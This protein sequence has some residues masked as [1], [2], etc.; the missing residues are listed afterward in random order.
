M[1]SY[2]VE[3]S[4]GAGSPVLLLPGGAASSRGFFPGLVEA[5]AGHQVVSLDRPGTGLAAG[6]GVAS[7][8]T[9]SAAAA[10]VLTSLGAGP[11][12]VVGQSLG[13]AVAVQFAMDHPS[14]VAGLVLIDP[15][16]VDIPK[17]PA[18]LVRLFGLL[19]LP[20]RLP[21]V[22]GRLDRFVWSAMSRRAHVAP[23]ARSGLEVMI[24]SA[25]MATTKKAVETLGEDVA[26]LGPRLGRLEVP[27][28]VMTADRKPG[29]A[30]RQSHERLVAALGGRL[31]A[32]AGGVHAE[33]LRKPAWV[34]DLVLS[35][36]AEAQVGL[37]GTAGAEV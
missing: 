34:N 26:L 32:P 3:V 8:R 35:V 33:H 18:T 20:G 13:G 7:L 27:V 21:V 19:A 15:T 24:A 2:E 29:H 5:L 14:L 16:P 30:V 9:G 4:G 10:E 36:V 37:P 28:V 22:G 1:T 25:S 31:V 12:V 17:L 11:A 6:K 23:E